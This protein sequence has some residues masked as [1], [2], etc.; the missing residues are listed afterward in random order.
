MEHQDGQWQS[1]MIVEA[2]SAMFTASLDLERLGTAQR[3]PER[4]LSPAEDV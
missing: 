3:M 1:T 2:R 4:P